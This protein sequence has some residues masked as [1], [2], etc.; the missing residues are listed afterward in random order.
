[1]SNDPPASKLF[2]SSSL[3]PDLIDA[4][5]SSC[6]VDNSST[7][8]NS[9]D[10]SPSTIFIQPKL[11][12]ETILKRKVQQLEIMNLS[13]RKKIKILQQQNRRQKVKI[14]ALQNRIRDLETNRTTDEDVS[15]DCISENEIYD[16]LLKHQIENDD[17]S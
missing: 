15:E 8:P 14:E 17:S 9:S 11:P 5:T 16:E 6:H 7:V 2:S 10:T 4:L 1:M 12:N 13:Y 3:N